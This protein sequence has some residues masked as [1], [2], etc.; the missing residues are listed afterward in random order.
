MC[1]RVY[2]MHMIAQIIIIFCMA[3]MM[4]TAVATT[5]TTMMMLLL[6]MMV[7]AV[8]CTRQELVSKI[9]DF[10]YSSISCQAYTMGTPCHAYSWNC[11]VAK[12]SLHSHGWR[13]CLCIKCKPPNNH[14]VINRFRTSNTLGSVSTV[15]IRFTANYIPSLINI[16]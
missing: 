5:T 10:I 11:M 7:A 3:M 6:M 1:V 4:M 16:I 14:I 8:A 12:I 9:F 2:F 15:Q 13:W